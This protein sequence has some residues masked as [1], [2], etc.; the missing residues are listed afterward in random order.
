MLDIISIGS[1]T[2]DVFIHVPDK[3]SKNKSCTFIPGT[4]VEIEDM[5][6]FTG[7]GATNTSVA[8][9]RLGLN[10]GILCAVG[11]DESASRIINE[12]KSEK[13]NTSNIIKLKK[14]ITSYSAIL[15]GFGRDR[16]ILFYNK[17][18]SL[19]HAKVDLKKVNAKWLYI[20]SLH[21]K[22]SLLKEISTHAKKINAKIAFNPGQ[23]ELSLGI[24]GL[25]KIFGKLDILLVN[26]EEALKL[27]GSAD[28]HRNLKKLLQL[29]EYVAITDGDNGAYAT[30]GEYSYFTSTF[31]IKRLDVTGAGDA[32]GS[33]FT[34][35][36]IKGKSV[37]Q[38][39]LYGTANANSVIRKLGTKN[40]LLNKN[41]INQFIKKYAKKNAIIKQKF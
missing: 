17:A 35:A 23:K 21:A 19:A 2:E 4:K 32:F 20:S 41:Q 6:H 7:G 12:L 29:A 36:I 37:E 18:A 22:T 5:S 38:A 34:S 33:G 28:V 15:T 40:I 16:V 26:K 8:F 27:T 39:L 10:T 14:K 9:S 13:I 1:A 25:Q 3:F 11:D 31:N 30:D 24:K